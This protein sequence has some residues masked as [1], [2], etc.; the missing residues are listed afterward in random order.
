MNK[1]LALTSCLVVSLIYVGTVQAQQNRPVDPQTRPIAPVVQDRQA[2][3]VRNQ[4]ETQ[5]IMLRDQEQMIEPDF[6]TEAISPRADMA[7]E[8]MSVVAQEVEKLLAD[9][10][11]T[12][13]IG[14][15]VREI[16]QKQQMAQEKIQT[17]LEKLEQ[18]KTFLK[19]MIG[20]DFKAIRNI[21]EQIEQNQ[22]RI[23]ELQE[24]QAQETD[25]AAQAELASFAQDLSIQNEALSEKIQ[26]ETGKKS[27]FGWLFRQFNIARD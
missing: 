23:E 14:E 2:I 11:R 3:N 10:E 5:Q 25:P 22:Q 6:D 20:P 8:K 18:R 27:L 1:S 4:G 12:G 26:T 21:E 17:H 16:A 24:L 7:R 9:P 19:S 15:K 13:G